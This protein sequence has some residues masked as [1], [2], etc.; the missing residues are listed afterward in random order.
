MTRCKTINTYECRECF[1][2]SSHGF[3]LVEL[4]V[5]IGVMAILS[6]VILVNVF[7][8]SGR[9]SFNS[10][11][12]EIVSTLREA[13]SRSVAQEGATAWGVHFE[14]ATGTSPFFALFKTSYN[15]ANTVGFH[16]LPTGVSYSS[17]SITQGSSLDV[18]FSQASGVPL[19]TSS[20]TLTLTAGSMSGT[21]STSTT[22]N[23]TSTGLIN[24]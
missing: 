20:I 23:I 7:N 1:C 13:E 16:R 22:I 3:S 17:S 6:S 15:S 8:K 9:G 5:V 10:T 11:V 4:L 12:Q 2:G 21:I 18:I 14:N 19:A 24:F